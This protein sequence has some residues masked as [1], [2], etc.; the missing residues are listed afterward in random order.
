M[1]DVGSTTDAGGSIPPH[2]PDLD[3]IRP[4]GRGGF[5]E[6]WLARNRT[7]GHLRA[8]KLIPLRRSGA[9]AGREI[10]SLSRLE[11]KIRRHPNLLSI[12]HV[13]QTA[14]HLFYVMDPADDLSGGPASSDPGYQPATLENRLSAGPLPPEQCRLCA[15]QLLEG[16]AALH[17]AGMVHRDVKPANCI[18]V[19]GELRL[20]D[21]GL[22]TEASP[23]ISRLGTQRYMPPDGRMDARA[24]V[25]AAGLV[26]YEMVTGLSADSFPRLGERAEETARDAA[27][28][29]LVRIALRACQPHPQQ[30]YTDAGQMLADLTS[31]QEETSEGRHRF[32]RRILVAAAACLA[33]VLGWWA[34]GTYYPPGVSVNFATYP[35]EAT[36]VLDGVPLKDA[37]D[38]EYT[39]PCT[40]DHL[41]ARR[42]HVAFKRAGRR[43]L[44]MGSID[45]AGNRQIV[46]R[47]P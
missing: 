9:A 4:I 6:V 41:P 5:G 26:I 23:L 36:V 47:W 16:L 40:V 45:F 11:S 24:D 39:T 27:L 21:F 32:R 12:H 25:Y 28:G 18:F 2:I 7:T 20:A 31:L 46:G 35:F 43:D 10:A 13:G 22:V 44:D 42:H 1:P 37:D 30:R 33:A 29:N 15:R 34:W 3:L 17:E 14:E 19:A 8:A 38:R